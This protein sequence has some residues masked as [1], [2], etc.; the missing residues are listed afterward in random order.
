MANLHPD[1]LELHLAPLDPLPYP[2]LLVRQGGLPR[3]HVIMYANL[4]ES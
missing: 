1:R 3:L 4:E 2:P